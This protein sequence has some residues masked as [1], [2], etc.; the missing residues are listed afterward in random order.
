MIEPRRDRNSLGVPA[1]SAQWKQYDRWCDL[2]ESA[3]RQGSDPLAE[4]YVD[5]A[6]AAWRDALLADLLCI[7]IEYRRRRGERIDASVLGERFPDRGEWIERLLAAARTEEQVLLPGE[8]VG[9]Y[10][11]EQA[12]ARGAFGSVYRAY[13][14][15]L[16][17]QVAI[18]VARAV[19]SDSVCGEQ[20]RHESQ[21]LASLCHPSIVPVYDWGELENGVP[22]VVMEYLA[23][24]S[25]ADRLGRG[26]VPWRQAVEWLTQ[27]ADAVHYIHLRGTIHRDLKPAN[28]V[29]DDHNRARVTD[30][31]LA[32]QLPS[33]ASTAEGFAGTPCYMAPEQLRPESR[34]TAAADIWSLGAILYESITGQRP[35]TREQL[36]ASATSPL[37]DLPL[38]S[39]LQPGVPPGVDRV[40]VKC[41]QLDPHHRF[42]SAGHLARQLRTCPASPR[43]ITRRRAVAA[44]SLVAAAGAVGWTWFPPARSPSN[45]PLRC[46]VNVLAWN[47]VQGPRWIDQPGALPVRSD[48]TVRVQI[49]SNDPAHLYVVWLD[50]AG[51]VTPLYPGREGT[52]QWH[53]S[54]ARVEIGLPA[55]D[56]EGWEMELA[57]PAMETVLV[58][59]RRQPLNKNQVQAVRDALAQWKPQRPTERVRFFAFRNGRLLQA[60]Q[61]RFR[62]PALEE[63][64]RLQHALFDNQRLIADQI[65]S[66][67]DDV[68]A[69]TFSCGIPSPNVSTSLDRKGMT[70]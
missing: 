24:Q 70:P 18:K 50:G 52:W 67:F 63:S 65:K 62:K 45:R 5:R 31:G 8:M 42:S 37:P 54:T 11:I 20:L 59:G 57:E 21:L 1:D 49:S 48:D 68:V 6:P 29:L 17:R 3:W 4:E 43:R 44:M 12:V 39:S 27:V 10:R 46:R 7:E 30:F 13:D 28:V 36:E 33:V 64:Q 58:M 38:P 23:G 47:P 69:L 40:C 35:Y 41:L 15:Q 55:A 60:K 51:M 66:M 19:A 61:D 34:A 53:H 26:P 56:G 32:F 9:R 22:Y 16:D 14:E 2:F 25:L